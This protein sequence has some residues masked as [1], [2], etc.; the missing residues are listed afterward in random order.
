MLKRKLH[1]QK[2]TRLYTIWQNIKAR[3]ERPTATHYHR[4]G[5]RGIVMCN[6]WKIQFIKFKEFADANGYND[7]L[8]IDRIDNDGNYEPLNCRFVTASENAQ[9]RID[10]LGTRFEED[11]LSEIVECYHNSDITQVELAN[12]VKMSRASIQ[13][14]LRRSK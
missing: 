13:R 10:S 7:S 8:Q 4:Y 3:C 5:G 2:G 6:E 12:Q 9:N 11:E 1:G 14:L